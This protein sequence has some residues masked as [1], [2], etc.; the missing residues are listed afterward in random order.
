MTFKSI[1][2][3]DADGLYINASF[4]PRHSF[5]AESKLVRYIAYVNFTNNRSMR[6]KLHFYQHLYILKTKI[7]QKK[8]NYKCINTMKMCEKSTSHAVCVFFFRIYHFISFLP[9]N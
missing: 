2:P 9:V 6:W 3:I 1:E 7:K 8:R 4:E 5:F